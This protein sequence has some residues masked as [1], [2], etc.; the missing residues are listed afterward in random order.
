MVLFDRVDLLQIEK[1]GYE[2][3]REGM[4]VLEEEVGKACNR[5]TIAKAKLS[6]LMTMTSEDFEQ[7]TEIIGNSELMNSEDF[8]TLGKIKDYDGFRN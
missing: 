7:N 1:T 6:K 8:F 5:E 4:K 3:I 2:L